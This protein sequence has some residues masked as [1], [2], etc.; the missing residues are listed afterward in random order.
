MKQLVPVAIAVFVALSHG[1]DEVSPKL[2]AVPQAVGS[3]KLAAFQ[4]AAVSPK[5]AAF[6]RA[7]AEAAEKADE[8]VMIDVVVT[9]A[10]SRPVKDL[11]PADL[12]LTDAGEPR[13]VETVRLQ[14]DGGRVVGI[15]LDEFHVRAGDA[16]SR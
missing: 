11:R 2:I 13:A 15:F 10:Q 14:T 8:P 6:R 9:D 3:P 7:A 16:T 12:E 5:L 1:P 4:R